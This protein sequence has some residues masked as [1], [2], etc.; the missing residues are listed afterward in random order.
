MSKMVWDLLQCN[1][2][3]LQWKFIKLFGPSKETGQ[4][5]LSLDVIPKKFLISFSTAFK[6]RYVQED[7]L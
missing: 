1:L 3:I 5:G 7:L 2:N 4:V 6:K